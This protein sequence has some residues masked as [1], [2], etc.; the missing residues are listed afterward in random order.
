MIEE[1]EAPM[2]DLFSSDEEKLL[3]HLHQVSQFGT[4]KIYR[5]MLSLLETPSPLVKEAVLNYCRR[6]GYPVTRAILAECLNGEAIVQEAALLYAAGTFQRDYLD[7]MVA[8][9]DHPSKEIQ[10]GVYRYLERRGNLT[11]LPLLD[12]EMD[13]AVGASLRRQIQRTINQIKRRHTDQT[14]LL[15]AAPVRS[16]PVTA[17]R[18]NNGFGKVVAW[19]AVSL[20]AIYLTIRLMLFFV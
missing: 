1:A 16:I 12:A 13:K 11:H 6:F 8:S 18:K 2:A 7:L 5:V 4:D 20:A 17:P 9:I 19:S 3:H 15:T 14:D 10:V